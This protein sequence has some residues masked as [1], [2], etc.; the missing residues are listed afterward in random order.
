[1]TIEKKLTRRMLIQAAAVITPVAL[2]GRAAS[3]QNSD[4][5]LRAD[6]PVARALA[7]FPNSKNVPDD[8]PLAASHEPSQTCATC[9]HVREETGDG[10]RRCPMFPGRLV[11]AEGWCSLWAKGPS[12]KS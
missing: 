4:I 11:N 10:T 3:A 5:V 1:M 8:N 7:Y 2:T 12:A 9:I 6:D